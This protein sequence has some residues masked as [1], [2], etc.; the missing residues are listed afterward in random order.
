MVEGLSKQDNQTLHDVRE[1]IDELLAAREQRREQPISEDELPADAEVI[2][3]KSSSTGEDA[4]NTSRGSPVINECRKSGWSGG[5]DGGTGV[6]LFC[7]TP[8]FEASVWQ[9]MTSQE[10][11]EQMIERVVRTVEA[12]TKGS[13]PDAI[14]AAHIRV[15][16][17]ANSGYPVK[18][19]NQA[20][21][22][23]LE[24]GRLTKHEETDG[25][26]VAQK[27]SSESF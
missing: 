20:I 19:V 21:A 18:Q 1:F 9:F 14:D 26:S 23:A 16:L 7:P 17:C 13:G 12:N 22:T 3:A 15:I 10:P 8:I 2:E 27:H 25:Y 5:D 6:S 24:Q 4:Q 11:H